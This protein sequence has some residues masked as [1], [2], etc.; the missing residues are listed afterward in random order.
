MKL[1]DS[2]FFFRES[3]FLEKPSESKDDRGDLVSGSGDAE[4][5]GGG[6]ARAVNIRRDGEIGQ[7]KLLRHFLD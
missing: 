4:G 7:V 6:E 3:T 2:N 1:K 5:E